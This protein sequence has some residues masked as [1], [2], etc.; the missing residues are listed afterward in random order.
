MRKPCA[1]THAAYAKWVPVIGRKPKPMNAD[2]EHAV[3][4]HV[5]ELAYLDGELAG[6]IELI[7]AADHLLLENLAV[8]PVYQRKGIGRRLMAH[9]E[10]LARAQGLPTVRLYTNKAFATNLEFYQ[11]LGYAIEA[12]EPIKSGG[13]LVHFAKVV[14]AP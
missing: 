12:E 4:V 9:V 13:F 7:P 10:A 3:R 5:I 14:E 1:L 6:L 2:Y 11:K 8:A